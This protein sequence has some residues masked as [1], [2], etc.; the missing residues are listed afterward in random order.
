MVVERR[1][2][3][4]FL[5]PALLT[6]LAVIIFPLAYT[7]RL[8]FSSWNI[9][10]PVLDWIGIEN[11]RGALKDGRFWASM[12]TLG[13]IVGI[14]IVLEYLIGLALALALWRTLRGGRAL[15]V[16][17]LLPMMVTP[18]IIAVVW[19]TMFHPSLGPVN[20]LLGR[21]GL[22]EVNWLSERVPALAAVIIVDVWQWTPFVFVFLLAGLI[23]LPREPFEAAAVDGAS[24]RQT[25]FFVTFRM[26]LPVSIAVLIIRLIEASK[27]MDT[28]YILTSGGPGTATETSS[29]YILIRGLR[30]FQIGYSASLSVLY[31]VVMIVGLTVLGK[32]LARATGRTEAQR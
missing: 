19:R 15:R 27:M 4:L 22:P 1:Y 17:F 24:P 9:S 20:D 26:L 7:V 14:A 23:S 8:S 18:A 5:L 28:V 16:L 6:L 31:L 13:V 3:Y 25:F 21:A 32:G 29:Y 11:Y 12:K 10:S 30:E 2:K